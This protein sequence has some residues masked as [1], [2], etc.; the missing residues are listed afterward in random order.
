[1]VGYVLGDILFGYMLSAGA[2]KVADVAGD[3]SKGAKA[4]VDVTDGKI[5]LKGQYADDA[6]KYLDDLADVGK[7]A[8]DVVYKSLDEGLNFS[9]TALRHF[10]DPNR[11]VPIQVLKDTIKTGIA[12]SDP[13]GT[14]GLMMYYKKVS[15]NGK[16]Y[17]LEVLYDASENMVKHFKYDRKPLGPLTEI[18][19]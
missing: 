10:E 15:I 2:G 12:T 3:F 16:N 7:Y 19:D 6:A 1:M 4:A 13:Q 8:D 18:I 11:F 5:I 17:N 14:K 9:S